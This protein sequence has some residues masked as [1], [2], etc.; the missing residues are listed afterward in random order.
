MPYRHHS[1][2]LFKFGD[3]WLY[4]QKKCFLGAKHH[5]LHPPRY[6]PYN[7][8]EQ[9]G[10]NDFRFDLPLQ[11]GIHLVINISHLKKYEPSHL[12]ESMSFSHPKEIHMIS[13]YH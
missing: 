11:L 3:Y 6:C 10:E 9:L 5:K 8:L 7:I 4:L 13:S 12:E 2:T 1:P